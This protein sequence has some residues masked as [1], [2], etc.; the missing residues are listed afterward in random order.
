MKIEIGL[1]SH[2]YNGEK[3]VGR[4]GIP[5][6]QFRRQVVNG[7]EVGGGHCGGAS[8]GQVL[9][10]ARYDKKPGARDIQRRDMRLDVLRLCCP[11][12][13]EDEGQ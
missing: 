2:V 8:H 3:V 5:L 11:S 12:R 1:P 6:R 4:I 7:D 10:I 13:F 9:T